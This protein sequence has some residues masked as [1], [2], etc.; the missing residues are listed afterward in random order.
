[1]P[2]RLESG[3][4]A[5]RIIYSLATIF[6]CWLLMQA[7]HEAGHVLG[8]SLTGGRVTNVVLHPLAISRTDVSPNPQPRV[9][10][11]AGP[12]VGVV[13]P[14]A[15]WL[16][17]RHWW[18]PVAPWL[19]FFAGFCLIAN[20]CYLG[21]GVVEPIGDAEELRRLG[22]PAWMLGLFAAATI[23]LGLR[24]WHGLGPEFG[25]GPQGQPVTWRRAGIA[26]AALIIV[27]VLE[28]C[29]IKMQ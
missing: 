9:E 20:G 13:L 7:V 26:S 27:V 10:V 19:R 21:Y 14:L 24:L 12:I 2:W 8:A 28:W 22:V 3:I 29:F 23:P 6:L 16:V 4:V 18:K 17:A 11:W 25:W 5:A 15:M 1:M